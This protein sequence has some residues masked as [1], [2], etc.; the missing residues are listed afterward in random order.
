M[1]Q[2]FNVSILTTGTTMNLFEAIRVAWISLTTH[3]LRALL[4]TLGII[5]GVGSVIGMQAIGN[6]FQRWMAS[7]FDRLGA[8]VVYVTP[9][10]ST[11]DTEE[12][13]DARLTAADAEALAQ[14]GALPAV[15]RVA[16]EFSGSSIVSA[17][18]ERF[19]YGVNGVTP[20]FFVI[21]AHELEAGRFFTEGEGQSQVRVAVIGKDIAQDL[22]GSSQ[23]A[24]GQRVLVDNVGFDVIGILSTRPN[25][26]TGGGFN[27]PTK[28]VFLP[29]LTARSRLFRNQMTARVD[30]SRITVQAVSPAQAKDAMRQVTIFLRERHH[31]T[32]QNNDFN[33]EN[34]EQTAQQ[35]QQAMAGF[36]AFLL[37][38]GGISLLVGGIGIMNIMLVSVTQRTREIGLRKAVGAR[39]RDIMI[40]FLIEA[41]VL[42]LVGGIIGIGLGYLLSFGGTFVMQN[43]FLAAGTSAVVTPESILLATGVATAI[44]VI[45]GFFP[46]LR[47]AGLQPVKALRSE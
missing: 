32:Y 35:A 28:T 26:A 38:V 7:E 17:G 40:Q 14:P 18:G 33:V 12:P 3:K 1:F 4:T 42:S 25:Q 27:E 44:G 41:I 29:Y 11:E 45:F 36:S 21:N 10:F 24:I 46:A 43:V 20:S 31:L 9:A 22:Y 30:L 19:S 47:A 37:V 23:A 13:I 39:K 15:A 8:G 34:V 5:I 2:C 16:Y 6:G